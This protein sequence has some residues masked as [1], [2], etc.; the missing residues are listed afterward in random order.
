MFDPLTPMKSLKKYQVVAHMYTT[1][2]H[3][4]YMYKPLY[5]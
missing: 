2:L 5:R 1:I 3:V 4:G